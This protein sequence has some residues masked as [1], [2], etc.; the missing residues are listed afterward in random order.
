MTLNKKTHIKN[1]VILAFALIFT[2]SITSAQNYY[3]NAIQ[4]PYVI[5]G[6]IFIMIFFS[7]M[8]ILVKTQLGHQRQY[9]LL[10]SLSIAAIAT[11][12]MSQLQITIMAS[13]IS[14]L[15]IGVALIILFIFGKF[16]YASFGLGGIFVLSG[17]TFIFI[18]FAPENTLPEFLKSFK[19][20]GLIIGIPLAITGAV[21]AFNQR[22]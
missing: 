18:S 8:A 19:D 7:S 5:L 3:D 9:A 6:A 16:A 15:G 12:Y 1:Y 4:N 22:R 20:F 13:V 2:V 11:F 21:I 10:V 14:L 17:L